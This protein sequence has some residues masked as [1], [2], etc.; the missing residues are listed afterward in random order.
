M[1]C[2][3][4]S[5]CE[6]ADCHHIH[7]SSSGAPPEFRRCSYKLRCNR[8]DCP[9]LL[10]N[11]LDCLAPCRYIRHIEYVDTSTLT[12]EVEVMTWNVLSDALAA[13]M[14]HYPPA[15][16]ENRWVRIQR[17][18]DNAMEDQKR[19]VCLQEVAET[20]VT[21]LFQTADRHGYRVLFDSWGTPFNGRMGN[22]I[23]V[24][25]SFTI[26]A[27]NR[28]RLGAEASLP[29]AKVFA[30]TI[31]SVVLENSETC[32]RFVIATVHMP[33]RFKTPEVMTELHSTLY[34]MMEVSHYPTIVAGDF[35]SKP[36]DMPVHE[37]IGSIWDH[38]P[39]LPTIH[40]KVFPDQ[41]EF[42]GCIDHILYTKANV[43]WVDKEEDENN[44]NN[45]TIST[46]SNTTLLPNL[47][48]PSDHI[49]VMGCFKIT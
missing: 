20:S 3:Y 5:T 45:S 38:T 12:S 14:T 24:P 1:Q 9:A 13:L 47:D 36:E 44:K 21:P 18:L 30:Q 26:I 33:C 34:R 16:M 48:H 31:T 22:A 41:P 49:P 40:S 35:N 42:L 2:R 6:R 25:P 4:Q 8:P 17:I 27:K 37:K 11:T 46:I 29:A 32:R 15:V 39:I 23:L 43:H 10:H 28:I 7:Q 19:I